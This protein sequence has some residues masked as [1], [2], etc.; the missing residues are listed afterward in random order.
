MTSRVALVTLAMFAV[1]LVARF[2]AAELVPFPHTEGSA[3]YAGVARNLA[4]GRGLVSD[5]VWSYA[6][7][8]LITPKPAFELWLPMASFMAAL[9]MVLLG[10]TF[11]N[12][13]LGSLLLGAAIA[14]LAWTIGREAAETHGLDSRRAAG[15]AIAS[16]L[17]AAVLG[18]FL[19]AAAGPDSTTPFLVFGTLAAWLMPRALRSRDAVR[20]LLGIVLGFAYLSRQEA[21]WLGVCFVAMVVVTLRG[22]PDRVRRSVRVLA[23]VVVG[24]LAVVGPWLVRQ[25]MTFGSPFPGQVVDNAFLR[26]GLDI[27]AWLDRPSLGAFLGQGPAVIIGNQLAALAH[28]LVN[29]LA[30][31]A[32]PVGIAGVVALVALRRSPVLRS[33][34]ALQALLVSGV[35]TFLVT[36]LVFPVATLSGTF[37]HASGPVLVGLIVCGALGGDALM[38]RISR[39]R[40]WPEPNSVVAPV[41]LVV[42]A[43]AMAALE[44]GVLAR[45]A[46]GTE[47]RVRQVAEAIR[48]LDQEA[49]TAGPQVRAGRPPVLISDHPMWLSDALSQPVVA[50]PDEDAVA[51]A[52]LAKHFDAG[53]L[54]VFDEH[55]RYPG[56]LLEGQARRCL[57][58]T[59]QQI[60][61]SEAPALLFRLDIGCGR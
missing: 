27:F 43:A 35:L 7:P 9:P 6:T 58:G 25:A 37:L 29:V 40:G 5:A 28:N 50:L 51:V 1:A 34:T 24:G 18:P 8:P 38:A 48:E 54:V 41:A 56:A 47:F 30:V 17:L 33:P 19:V 11:A 16:G 10:A 32:F 45:Q 22:E 57:A 23:P 52:D 12:A 61:P 36:S 20:V 3:W 2:V 59:P 44:V 53:W 26:T 42:V 55:G 14:P 4:S 13:Q 49:S 39:L 21:V 31:P 60:G 15:V 46:A